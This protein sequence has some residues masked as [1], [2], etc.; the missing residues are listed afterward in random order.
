[1]SKQGEVSVLKQLF[2]MFSNCKHGES[3]YTA[4]SGDLF[5]CL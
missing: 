4:T 2:L 1:M 3:D 5:D